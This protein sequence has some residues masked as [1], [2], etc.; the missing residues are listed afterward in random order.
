MYENTSV[1]LLLRSSTLPRT[2]AKQSVSQ[3]K[4]RYL[5]GE[6]TAVL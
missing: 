4:Y 6:E 1:N 5:L 3:D 2:N